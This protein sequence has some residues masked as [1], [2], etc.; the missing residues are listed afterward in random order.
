MTIQIIYG[1]IGGTGFAAGTLSVGGVVVQRIALRLR[2]REASFFEERPA[3]RPD[4][5][6]DPDRD[7][8]RRPYRA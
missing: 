4:P 5:D 1:I 8:R 6:T 2:L 7:P 3:R